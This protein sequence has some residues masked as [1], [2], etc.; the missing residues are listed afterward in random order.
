MIILTFF[1]K[2]I[3]NKIYWRSLST[4]KFELFLN[5]K[6]LKS[7]FISLYKCN[8]HVFFSLK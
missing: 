5:L 2:I 7:V 6:Q 4:C 1:K 3:K 8:K